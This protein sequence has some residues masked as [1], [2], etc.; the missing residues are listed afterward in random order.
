MQSFSSGIFRSLEQQQ[1]SSVSRLVKLKGAIRGAIDGSSLEAT[2]VPTV[3]DALTDEPQVNSQCNANL[4]TNNSATQKLRKERGQSLE[5]LICTFM[6]SIEQNT[7]Y[8]EDVIQTNENEDDFQL[9]SGPPGHS[10]IF[11]DLFGIKTPTKHCNQIAFAEQQSWIRGP[12]QCLI[13]I[14][15]FQMLLY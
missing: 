1:P 8:G 13:Y 14:R 4:T 5:A 3:W 12:S 9:P 7:D 15:T 6:Q 10:L 2:E 11:G